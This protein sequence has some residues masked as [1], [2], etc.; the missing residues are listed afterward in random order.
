MKV[1]TN[2]AVNTKKFGAPAVRFCGG[3]WNYYPRSARVANRGWNT[4]DDRN[5]YLGLRLVRQT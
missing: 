5:D 3:S 2:E 4:P 1:R